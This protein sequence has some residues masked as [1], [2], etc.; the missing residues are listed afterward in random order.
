[1]NVDT[2]EIHLLC[3]AVVVIVVF[4]NIEYSIYF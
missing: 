2:Y 4:L 3:T 1:M